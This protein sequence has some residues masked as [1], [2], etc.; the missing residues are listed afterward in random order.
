MISIWPL[1][2]EREEGCDNGSGADEDTR[3]GD[4]ACTIRVGGCR[5]GGRPTRRGGRVGCGAR[6]RGRSGRRTGVGLRGVVG[7]P[8]R[9]GEVLG[10]LDRVSTSG[11]VDLA[12]RRDGIRVHR[13]ERARVHDV[14]HDIRARPLG[15][16]G[17]VDLATP[18]HRGS[19]A[20]EG[21]KVRRHGGEGRAVGDHHGHHVINS[22]AVGAID[23]AR[24]D[25]TE[26]SLLAVDIVSFTLRD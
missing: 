10:E 25:G 2:L 9:R 5:A 12:V 7:D 11:H 21:A 18:G 24:V 6:R 20:I 3:C 13:K 15:V 17:N 1:G 22:R 19:T 14:F 23:T 8:E 16:R 26:H 4:L